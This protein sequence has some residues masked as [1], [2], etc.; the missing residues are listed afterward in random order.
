MRNTFLFLVC[1]SQTES[2]LARGILNAVELFPL[3]M[4]LL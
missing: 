4:F 2:G 1:L 3:L